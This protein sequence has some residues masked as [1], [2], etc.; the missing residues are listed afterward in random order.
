MP[1]MR[2]RLVELLGGLPEPLSARLRPAEYRYSPRDV[3]APPA[4]PDT[5]I[6][7][8]IGP[9]NFAAQGYRFARAA[10]RLPGVG[11]ASMQFRRD[12]DFGFPSDNAVPVRV[13][14]FSRRWQ[15]RQ[16]EAV[17]GFT[18]VAIEA[19]RPLFGALFDADPVREV[20]ALRARGVR[21]AFISHGSDLRI[22][23]RHRLIDEWSP[24]NEAGWTRIP[25]LEAKS[26][27]YRE[28][29]ASAQAPVFVTTPDMLLDWP[30]ATWL[31]VVVDPAAWQAESPPLVRDRPV[32]VHAPTNAVIKGSDLIDPAMKRMHDAGLIDYRR[33]EGVPAAQMPA[34]YTDADIVLEQFRIGTYSVAAIEAMAAGRVVVAHLHDQVREHVRSTHGREIPVVEATI[35]SLES[36]LLDVLARR[37]HYRGIAATGPAFVNGLHNG[38][39]TA[40]AL[41]PF[42]VP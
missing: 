11:A 3:P 16:F 6:R 38:S 33:I 36:V 28:L 32:V 2:R 4:V 29:L 40:E 23:S 31:P 22:P 19:G 25:E 14:R 27:V 5:P 10:E 39:A 21:V 17:A 18:H 1:G 42:L 34:L 7:L 37:D 20:A 24:F 35:D 9:V 8:Y 13:F 30:G 12:I 26:Q 15:M 41:R